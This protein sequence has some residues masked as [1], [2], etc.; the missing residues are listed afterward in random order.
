VVESLAIER[1]RELFGAEHANVQPHSGAQANMAAY[2]ALL[3]PGD[4][5]LGMS[6]S[7]GGHLTHGSPVN[8]SG[9]LYRAVA[10]GLGSE[11]PHRL[12]PGPG[13]GAAAPA[14]GHRGGCQCV[15]A[16]HRLRGVRRHRAR[17]RGPAGGGHGPHRGARGRRRAPEP[18][19]HADV[20]TS[21][22]HKTLRGPR[23]GF[24]LC[25][26]EH[27]KAID[28]A[29]F[30]GMQGGP[31]MHVIAAKAVAFREALEPSFREY[32]RN[33][34]ENAHVLWRSR[35]RSTASSW[36]AAAPTTTCCWWT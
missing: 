12:R 9:Q 20:V 36:S 10:Y 30:P 22:T 1:A 6:L 8:S 25:R 14:A 26:E 34:V 15:P 33:V 28:K 16:H 35:C 4:T 17:S 13:A 31:L 19:A 3:K 24:V 5:L 27:A 21:T 11:R 32:A 23:S 7:H 2:L 18:G 29:V